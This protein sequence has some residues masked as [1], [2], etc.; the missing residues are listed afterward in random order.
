MTAAELCHLHQRGLGHACRWHVLLD[1]A[2]LPFDARL[3]VWQTVDAAEDLGEIDGLDRDPLLLQQLLAEANRIEVGGAC[4]DGADAQVAQAV[5]N[6]ADGGK[7]VEV[8]LE[9]LRIGTASVCSL[10]SE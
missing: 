6:A 7:P 3:G 1:L 10:V 9:I 4:A 8:G 5:D 2:Q